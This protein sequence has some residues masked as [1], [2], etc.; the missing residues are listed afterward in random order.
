MVNFSVSPAFV[1]TSEVPVPIHTPSVYHLNTIHMDAIKPQLAFNSNEVRHGQYRV[2]LQQWERINAGD[3]CQGSSWS[4]RTVWRS[5]RRAC[6]SSRPAPTRVHAPDFRPRSNHGKF[7]SNQVSSHSDPHYDGDDQSRDADAPTDGD[8][9]GIATTILPRLA[10]GHRRI[11]VRFIAMA[12]YMNASRWQD[13]LCAWLTD[14]A[15]GLYPA[16]LCRP[17]PAGPDGF[18]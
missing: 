15:A 17:E 5:I 1:R 14:K 10:Y 8:K 3:P 11:I 2:G 13:L 9:W 16:C 4:T 12:L 6:A 18:R 7:Q